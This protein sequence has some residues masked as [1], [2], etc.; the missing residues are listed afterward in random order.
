MSLIKGKQIQSLQAAKVVD[1][2]ERRFLT[3][4]QIAAFAAKAETS[5]VEAA[6]T[7]AE[8]ALAA[9]RIAVTGE[10]GTAKAEAVQGAN[11]HSD[12]ALAAARLEVTAEVE[13]AKTVASEALAAARVAVTAEVGV[14][15]GEAI[16]DANVHSDAALA[17][18]RLEVTSE[19]DAAKLVASNALEAAIKATTIEVTSAKVEAIDKATAYT[20]AESLRL[21]AAIKETDDKVVALDGKVVGIESNTATELGDR[22]TKAEV[23][24][25]L[26]QLGA[27]I[28][29][30]GTVA[31]YEEITTKFPTP[32][33]GWLVAVESIHKFYVY[34]EDTVSWEEFPLEI[35]IHTTFAKTIRLAVTDSQKVIKTG[36]KTNGEGAMQSSPEL[37]QEVIL[38]VGGISQTKTVD[39]TVEVVEEELQVTWLSPD[40]ELEASDVVTLTY[41]QTA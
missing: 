7:A 33:E 29:Y 32:G 39:Y 23:D 6:K 28:K 4:V 15:K 24:Q 31:S 40:F 20:D 13:A 18:A 8:E 16:V 30:K 9:A 2:A 19:V 1:S 12:E 17:A 14:A 36:I 35:R 5:D 25:K 38:R 21:D 27:G 41:N 3:D 11:T 34:D 37:A 26:A 22:Y 10:I